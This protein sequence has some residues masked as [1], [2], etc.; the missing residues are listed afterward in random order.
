MPSGPTASATPADCLQPRQGPWEALHS[1]L[2]DGHTKEDLPAI[3]GAPQLLKIYSHCN[4]LPIV[5]RVKKDNHF[6]LGRRSFAW[7]KTEYPVLDLTEGSPSFIYPLGHIP[8]PDQ[9][10]R[11]SDVD[12]LG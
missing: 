8:L 1:L 12:D 11:T 4:S 10:K 9:L 5:V 7:E 6:L 2:K 3:G